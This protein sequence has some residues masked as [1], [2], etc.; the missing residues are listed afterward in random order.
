MGVPCKQAGAL[1]SARA[2]R[3]LRTI[4]DCYATSFHFWS[5]GDLEH[6]PRHGWTI[7]MYELFGDEMDTII[8]ELKWRHNGE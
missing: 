2:G 1:K 6:E 5:W 7:K 3:V 4:G 8:Q